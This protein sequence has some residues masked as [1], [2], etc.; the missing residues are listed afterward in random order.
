M[1][2]NTNQL[3][4]YDIDNICLELM[5]D[6]NK[7]EIIVDKMKEFLIFAKELKSTDKMIESRI[8]DLSQNRP[9]SVYTIKD[10]QRQMENID[11]ECVIF[12]IE[13]ARLFK[14]YNSNEIRDKLPLDMGSDLARIDRTGPVFEVVRDSL[15]QKLIFVMIDIEDSQINYIKDCIIEFLRKHLKM[16]NLKKEDY[17]IYKYGNQVRF[18][19]KKIVLVNK[20]EK[21]YIIEDF[22][23]FLED[24]GHSAVLQKLQLNPPPGK[25][26]GVT[27]NPL[28]GSMI[29]V[30]RHTETREK[31]LEYL[32]T[33]INNHRDKP[34][35]LINLNVI[36][37]INGNNN[38]IT[39]NVNTG[40]G[41][42]SNDQ[43]DITIHRYKKGDFYK[44]I[45]DTKP[46]WY[47]ENN[48]V[49]MEVIKN[50]YNEFFNE[51]KNSSIV[52]RFIGPVLF[53]GESR[54]AHSTKKRLA[55]FS[56]LRQHFSDE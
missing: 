46:E 38:N 56:I 39:S 4:L 49:E 33:N 52:S 16:I 55:K 20:A 37:N 26:I 9:D 1:D 10:F 27:L 42:I 22:Y 36:Q 11:R 14:T 18:I 48:Y 8:K 47:K 30:D 12:Y 5:N 24:E 31:E 19:F 53:T 32:V 29:P 44:H 25:F 17:G 43:T 15:A 50:A 41:N 13:K 45:Y 7:S 54:N 51:N 28:P 21:Q 23:R 3:I 34:V 40:S 2:N 6:P 35:N